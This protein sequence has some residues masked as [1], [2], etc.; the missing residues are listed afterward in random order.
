MK[1]TVMGANGMLGHDLVDACREEG[2]E[3]AGFDLPEVDITKK[4]GGLDKLS[5]CDWLINCAAYTDVD[6][7]ESHRETAFAVNGD[8]AGRVATWCA[9]HRVPLIHISTDYVFDGLKTT[10]YKESDPVRPLSVYGE[11]KLAG[12][13][14][15]MSACRR[16]IIVR[17]QSLF[18]LHGRSFVRSIMGRL[19]SGAA[20]KVVTDQVSAP[21]YTVHLAKAILRLIDAGQEGIVHVS[22]SGG[23]SWHEFACAIAARVKPGT[24]VGKTTSAEYKAPARR[25]ANSLLDNSR[26]GLL[27]GSVMPAW[28]VGLDE[29]LMELK[30]TQKGDSQ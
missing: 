14:A 1:V 3:V 20:L 18:G 25:P 19:E 28:Q 6:G 27:T 13:R 26:Y 30:M 23:C 2:I 8:G 7:A 9:E 15:V 21:T 5:P 11:S 12:E 10:P 17:T 16:H 24:E 22:A 29:Y 4:D